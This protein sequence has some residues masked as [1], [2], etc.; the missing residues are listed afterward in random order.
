MVKN[1]ALELPI[2]QA[3]LRAL[4]QAGEFRLAQSVLATHLK[5]GGMEALTHTAVVALAASRAPK[6]T[7]VGAT[8]SNSASV[9]L[10]LGRILVRS[11]DPKDLDRVEQILQN[12]PPHHKPILEAARGVRGQH[13]YDDSDIVDDPDE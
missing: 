1:H 10:A 8:E 6:D 4:V 7:Y 11:S 13:I 3:A 2:R 5:H 12:A 9:R